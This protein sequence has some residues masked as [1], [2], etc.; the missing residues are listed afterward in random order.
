MP[1]II[2][3]TLNE[4]KFL[5]ALLHSIKK[6]KIKGY[7]IIIADNNSKDKTK[8]IAKK[9][10][11]GIVNGG[12]PGK[13][14]NNGARV[15]KYDLLFLDAD[16][17]LP[18]NF[19]KRFLEKIKKENLDF[20]SCRIEPIS[21]NL[22][23][24]FYYML[25]NYGNFLANFIMMPHASGQ[26]LFMKKE[27]FEKIKGYDESLFLGEEHDLVRRA[28]KYGKGKLFMDIFVLNHPRRL[29]KEG[30][31]RTLLKD[32]KSIFHRIFKGQIKHKLYNKQYG[33]YS[34]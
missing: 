15:A 12:Y 11:C 8:L 29:E 14:R 2:I 16:V 25:K 27:L 21:N 34:Q 19:L 7:E 28:K 10:H 33:H 26:C 5:A 30:T 17:V 18:D 9:F 32:F 3:P 20:A 31:Y 1:S 24:R 13:A 22:N 23:H 4:E 6:Q